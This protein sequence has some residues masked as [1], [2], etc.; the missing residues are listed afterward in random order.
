MKKNYIL[1]IF[2]ICC[3]VQQVDIE[4]DLNTINSENIE[5]ET[6]KET[7]QKEQENNF[8]VNEKNIPIIDDLHFNL[9]ENCIDFIGSL[10]RVDCLSSYEVFKTLQFDDAVVNI[11][12]TKNY[13]YIVLKGG[14]IFEFNFNDQNLRQIFQAEDNKQFKKLDYYQLL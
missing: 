10:H 4:K 9:L 3:S 13:L 11:F 6:I 12:K 14:K 5:N 2:L 8:Y 7:I 1:L